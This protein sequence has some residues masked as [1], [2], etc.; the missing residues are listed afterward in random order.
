MLGEARMLAGAVDP[1]AGV[2]L[3]TV[4]E[5]GD[6]EAMARMQAEVLRPL[7]RQL[8]RGDVGQARP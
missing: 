1:P 4:T 6:V 5:P 2:T 7:R 8:G 3:R